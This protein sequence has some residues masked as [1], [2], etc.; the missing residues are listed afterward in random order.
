MNA[1]EKVFVTLDEAIEAIKA[2]NELGLKFSLYTKIE[3]V[4][5]VGADF[6]NYP[7]IRKTQY[8]V[9]LPEVGEPK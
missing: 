8:I 7:E 5:P 6:A 2:A 4:K 1:M 3:I 9:N